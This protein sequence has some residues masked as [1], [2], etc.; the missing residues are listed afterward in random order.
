MPVYDGSM[1]NPPAPLARVVLRNP[2]NADIVSDVPMLLDSGA[3][4][5]LIPAESIDR[6]GLTA[7]A[8]ELYE[9]MGFDGCTSIASA[10]RLEMLFMNKTFR[11]RFLIIDQEWGVVGRDILNLVAL[12]LDGPKLTWCEQRLSR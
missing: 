6:L 8:D 11:G 3:D 9:L 2:K 10:V 7:N 4:I 1:F 12:L 5:T